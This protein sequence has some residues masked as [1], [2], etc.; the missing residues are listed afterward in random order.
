[1]SKKRAIDAINL[2][3]VDKIPF[4][5]SMYHYNY[6]EEITGINPFQK[7]VR[8]YR[9][10]Y[11]FFD[12]DLIISMP[13]SKT[14]TIKFTDGESVREDNGNKFTKWGVEGSEW[15][16]NDTRFKNIDDILSYNPLNDKTSKMLSKKHTLE[17]INMK[18]G[19]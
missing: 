9:D 5:E 10:F 1:M 14:R 6:I 12:V 13:Y 7:P 11:K 2:K 8:A 18:I 19:W 16:L 4:S 3:E 15:V 17:T